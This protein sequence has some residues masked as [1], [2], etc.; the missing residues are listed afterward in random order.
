MKRSKTEAQETMERLLQVAREEFADKGYA[1]TALEMVA[2]IAQVTRGALYHHFKNKKGLFLAVLDLVQREVSERVASEAGRSSEP[3]EQLLL[4]CR[5]F[6]AAA[7]EP[8]NMRIMLIDG[9]AVAGWETWRQM[10]EIHSMRHLREQLDG[11]QQKG[12]M[13]QLPVDA[14]THA[15]SGAMNECSLWVAEAE[16]TAQAADESMRIIET[17]LTGFRR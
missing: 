13:K 3:W 8:Q 16:D 14:M 7:V 17:M 10:D 1:D 15:L 4:G 12:E 2:D 9:P 5:A 11:M 6:I